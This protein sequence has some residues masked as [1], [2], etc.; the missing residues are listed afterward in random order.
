[1]FCM[2]HMRYVADGH[3]TLGGVFFIGKREQTQQN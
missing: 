2:H 1:M 3:W